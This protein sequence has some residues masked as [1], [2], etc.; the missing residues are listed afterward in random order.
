MA[1][2][3]FVRRGEARHAGR[4]VSEQTHAVSVA[5][6]AT[7]PSRSPDVGPH[8]QPTAGSRRLPTAGRHGQSAAGPQGPRIP[9]LDGLRAFAVLGVVAF[10][11]APSWVPGG[12]LGVD[13]F[14]VLSGFLITTLLLREVTATRWIRLPRFWVRRARRLLPALALVLVTSIPVARLVEPDLTVGIG[15]QLLGA[16][17]FST[18]WVEIA[19]GTDYF[20][21]SQPEL[22][23]ILWSLA[24]EEQFYLAWPVLLVILLIT[25]RSAAWRVRIVTTAALVSVLAMTLLFTPV[26]GPG[27]DPTRVYYG[28]DTHAFGL[29]LGAAMTLR[30]AKSS[31]VF[32]GVRARLLPPL[33]LAGLM[34]MFLLLRSDSPLTYPLGLLA[35]SLLALV[36][37]LAC[38]AA[39]TEPTWFTAVLEAPALRWVGERSY[40][41][42]L[43]HWPVACIVTAAVR[44][45]PGTTWWGAGIGLSVVL[46]V[47][48]AAA[49]YRWVELP[50]RR[51]GFRGATRAMLSA[52][53]AAAVGPKGVVVRTVVVL[54]VLALVGS[55]AAVAYAPERTATELAIQAG[56]QAGAQAG[57]GIR[58]DVVPTTGD[59]Q[60]GASGRPGEPAAASRTGATPEQPTPEQPSDQPTPENLPFGA[61]EGAHVSAFGDSVLAAATPAILARYP[62][63]HVEGV[64][65][66]DWLDAERLIRT[67]QRE[68][69]IRDTVVLNFGTNAGFQ[70]DGS[71]DAA[72]RVLDLIGPE[73]RV[74]LVNTVGISYWVPDA[75]KTLARIAS[76]RA[77]VEVADWHALVDEHPGLLHADATHP[78]LDGVE[79]YTDLVERSFATLE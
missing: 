43:W 31:P 59:G 73:R 79:A 77:N 58:P 61:D 20:D 17:T 75:N 71:V 29:L 64:V 14:F 26:H 33:A 8:G 60:P 70:L 10:H 39:R 68:G 25:V 47:L 35:A 55:G 65:S 36:L 46:T 42:Y 52:V 76:G 37:V 12:F 28:T 22:L 45:Q 32:Q 9:G 23:R 51:L 41:I 30:W 15:R 18:N 69:R 16:L 67:A 19:A 63:A 6:G 74:V 3:G 54:S 56:L 48:A 66:T 38:D 2:T 72:E 57:S 40:G 49:S 11:L 5:D 13:V 27:V 1:L 53:R 4:T 62:R 21:E 50:V 44:A 78:N 34:A 24:I 7:K